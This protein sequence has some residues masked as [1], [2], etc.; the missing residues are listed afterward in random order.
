MIKNIIEKNLNIEADLMKCIIFDR[1]HNILQNKDQSDHLSK[2]N[3]MM[4][5]GD[6]S[7]CK[8]KILENLL[9]FYVVD[10]IKYL[11]KKNL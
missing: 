10:Q 7:V 5:I 8:I 3:Y 9:Y 6:L 1:L 4:N 2:V 11:L